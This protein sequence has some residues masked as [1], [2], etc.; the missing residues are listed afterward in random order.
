MF[1]DQ[2]IHRFE[3]NFPLEKSLGQND[4]GMYLRSCTPCGY[5]VC[6]GSRVVAYIISSSCGPNEN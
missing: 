2:L 1:M 6:K 5:L 3:V 4:V